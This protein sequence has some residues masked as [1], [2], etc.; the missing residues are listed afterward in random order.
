MSSAPDLRALCCP[1]REGGRGHPGMV[2]IKAGISGTRM[3]DVM[4]GEQLARI[5]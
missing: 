4:F 5:F 1:Y 3:L 2:L